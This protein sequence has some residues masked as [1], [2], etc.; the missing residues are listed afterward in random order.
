LRAYSESDNP[1]LDRREFLFGSL[2]PGEK[3]SW[4]VNIKLPREMVSR[5]DEVAIKFASDDRARLDELKGEVN[6]VELPRPAFAYSWQIVDR[7]ERC[8]G[9]GIAQLGETVELALEVKN[10]GVG[11]AIDAVASL[12]NK[13]DENVSLNKGRAKL[14]EL[15]PGESNSGVFEFEIK[16]EL[17]GD[18]AALQLTIGDEATD[19]YVAE[20][21]QVPVKASG[22]AAA[23]VTAAGARTMVDT[24]IYGAATPSSPVIARVKKGV[25]LPL[26]ARFGDLYRV[27]L[28]TRPGFVAARDV[29]EARTADKTPT[30]ESLE[31]R[32]EPKIELGVDTSTGGIATDGERF[33]LTGAAVDKN[34][35]R[36]LYIFVNDQKVFFQA[37]GEESSS[38]IRFAADFPLKVGNNTVV[39]VARENQDFQAR[40]LLVIHRR[41]AEIAQKTA[42][43]SLPGEAMPRGLTR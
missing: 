41:S 37:A 2:A 4:S 22:E 3:R 38:E 14:G 29:K 9:D 25:I 10:V 43:P 33:R 39:V 23:K 13:A 15:K 27:S 40:R 42:G 21:L 35:L 32:T 36:D 5:R 16:P 30:V 7:C 20:K 34:S 28:G 6:I 26:E 1:F 24:L 8:N 18:A 19:E 12:K 17:K 11:K 31:I